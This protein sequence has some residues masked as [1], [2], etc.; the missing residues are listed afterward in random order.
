[1][2]HKLVWS[3]FIHL[4]QITIQ[5]RVFK[6]YWRAWTTSIVPIRATPNYQTNCSSPIT[7]RSVL[8]SP[9]SRPVAR[10]SFTDWWGLAATPSMIKSTS[11]PTH[12]ISTLEFALP[13]STKANLFAEKQITARKKNWSKLV[14]V[15][16]TIG[17]WWASI[18]R[19]GASSKVKTS[20]PWPPNTIKRPNLSTSLSINS[21]CSHQIRAVIIW[22]VLNWHSILRTSLRNATSPAKWKWT[23]TFRA[24]WGSSPRKPRCN[25]DRHREHATITFPSN[26]LRNF[27]PVSQ[28]TIQNNH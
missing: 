20:Q 11:R 9:A 17:T 10:R 23:V 5:I 4:F 7:I 6:I 26:Y 18:P 16:W 8:A 2:R 13:R 3:E 15:W 28:V 27:K 1:M 22:V 21:K 24:P 19:D 25:R 12:R 14:S